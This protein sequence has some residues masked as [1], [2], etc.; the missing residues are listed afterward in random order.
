MFGVALT[1]GSLF[2]YLGVILL[3]FGVL[4]RIHD[5]DALMAR[6]F[7]NEYPEYKKSTKALVP[8]IW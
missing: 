1:L 6:Q 7:P 5:E 2:A 4:I 8:F 3:I